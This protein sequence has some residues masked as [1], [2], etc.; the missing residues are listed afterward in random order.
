MSIKSVKT[1]KTG[2]FRE[3]EKKFLL[4]AL[5]DGVHDA[6]KISQGY[7]RNG[8]PEVRLR[9]KGNKYFITLKKGEGFIRSEKELEIKKSLFDLLWE[10]TQDA[11]IEKTRYTLIA[12]DGLTW[13]I[14]EYSGNL[15]GLITAE[16]ELPN[17]N[18]KFDIPTEVQI[19]ILADI[20][21]DKRYKNK[22][23]A[24]KGIPLT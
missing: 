8:D 6:T 7:V 4:S 23:L 1:Y 12:Q 24:T 3:I 9:M 19:V 20:T 5:P 22:N 11:R 2:L 16:V 14:D 15:K 18:A 10:A 21:K 17:E 13:E